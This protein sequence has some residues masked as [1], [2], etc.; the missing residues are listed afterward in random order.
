MD[1]DRNSGAIETSYSILN[2][3]GISVQEDMQ[4]VDY[5]I[6]GDV[7]LDSKKLE[8]MKKTQDSNPNRI[9]AKRFDNLKTTKIK[10]SDLF[11]KSTTNS[12]FE[13]DK[14]IDEVRSFDRKIGTNI[15][16]ITNDMLDNQALRTIGY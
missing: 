8:K 16:K 3:M 11:E 1:I 9:Q 7:G 15:I 4:H 14:C 6:L 12:I 2:S 10:S 5:S 13:L